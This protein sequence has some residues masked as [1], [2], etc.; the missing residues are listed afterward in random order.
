MI[1]YNYIYL[2]YYH[3]VFSNINMCKSY[4]TGDV[5]V[6]VSFC[7][8]IEVFLRLRKNQMVKKKSFFL[9]LN[10][11]IIFLSYKLLKF[12]NKKKIN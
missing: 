12:E 2:L 8:L 5:V 7:L 11:K 6:N 3:I 9:P 1:V 10:K 4:L